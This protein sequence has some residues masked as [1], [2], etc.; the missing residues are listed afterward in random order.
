MNIA[1]RFV[2]GF[3]LIII[4]FVMITECRNLCESVKNHKEE[5][6]NDES[7]TILYETSTEFLP[8]VHLESTTI[9]FIPV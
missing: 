6:I 9:K 5:Q 4:M 1:K 8:T 7:S 3:S 2:V